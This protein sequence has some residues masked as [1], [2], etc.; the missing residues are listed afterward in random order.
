VGCTA[1]DFGIVMA[2]ITPLIILAAYGY[3]SQ[4]P[5]TVTHNLEAVW[6]ITMGLG[7][8]VPLTVFYFRW[9]M[10]IST[11]FAESGLSNNKLFSLRLWLVIFKT[12]WRRMIGTCMCW[13]LYDAVAYPFGLFT[14]TIIDQL[15]GG[16]GSLIHSIGYGALINAFLLPGCIVGAYSMDYFGRRNTQALD[17]GIQTIVAFVLGGALFP[18]QKIFPLFVVLYG[19]LLALGEAGPGVATI[20]IS[21]ESY[22]T[23]IRGIMIGLSAAFGKAGAAIGTVVFGAIQD[24]L[25][26]DERGQQG[27]FLVGA[28]FSALGAI[29]TMLCLPD[30][31]GNTHLQAEDDRFAE[32]LRVNGISL[33]PDSAE[34]SKTQSINDVI[35]KKVHNDF[36]PFEAVST[37]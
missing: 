36:K 17:F 27:V 30:S 23:M 33:G 14:S 25:G 7:A 10:V 2:G 4:T 8:V 16:D 6:R 24:R 22:P 12:Y 32:I 3:T 5:S 11:R 35:E 29:I 31:R 18:I 13:A 20:L 26:E 28:A 1:I 37:L 15:S 19:V 21:A 9:K 34:S